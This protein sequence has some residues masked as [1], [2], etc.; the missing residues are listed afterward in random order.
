MVAIDFESAVV[1]T[2]DCVTT[3]IDGEIVLLNN[4]T[5]RYQGLSGV[6]PDIWERIQEPT[7][8]VDIVSAL[9]GEYDVE[10]DRV[11]NDVERFLKTLAAEQLIKVD[12]SP[13]P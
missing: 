6:G 3:T 4:E 10:R 2:D 8:P 5:G 9:V 13:I 12:A 7:E 11:A 1:A